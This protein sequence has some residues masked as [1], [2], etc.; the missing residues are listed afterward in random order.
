MYYISGGVF[1]TLLCGLALAIMVAILEFCWNTKKN[2]SQGRQSLCSEMGQVSHSACTETTAP[3]N[4][5]PDH[6]NKKPRH[7]AENPR[8]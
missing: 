3:N 7:V 6:K 4:V 1:V 8:N 5:K 2:A